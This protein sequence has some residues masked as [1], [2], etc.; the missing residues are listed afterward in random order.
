VGQGVADEGHAAQYNKG[1]G[2]GAGYADQHPGQQRL[3]HEFVGGE[4]RYEY[5]HVFKLSVAGHKEPV[6]CTDNP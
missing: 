3:E 1:A 2:D 6:F 5:I 4:R